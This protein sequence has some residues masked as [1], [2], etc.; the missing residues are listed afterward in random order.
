MKK[1]KIIGM[2]NQDNFSYFFLNK[3]DNFFELLSKILYESFD[4]RV[5]EYDEYENKKGKWVTKK[6]SIRNYTDKHEHHENKETRIDTFFGKNKIFV[7]LH[8]SPRNRKKFVKS[9]NKYS[10]WKKSEK[11]PSKFKKL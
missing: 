2:G 4:M 3:Q 6:K 1:L 10:N 11:H 8:A 9:L 5:I 7:T